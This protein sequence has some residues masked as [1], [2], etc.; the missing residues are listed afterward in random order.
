[1][2][3][4]ITRIIHREPED[5]EKPLSNKEK[6]EK[7]KTM[8]PTRAAL[9]QMMEEYHEES[10]KNEEKYEIYHQRK[11]HAMLLEQTNTSSIIVFPSVDPPWYKIGWNSA[12]IYAY[13]VAMRACKKKDLPT[14]RQDTDHDLRSRDGI[15]FVRN[16]KSFIRRLSEIGLN[17]YEVL[18]DG[19]YV[20]DVNHEYTKGE[21]KELRNIKYRSGEEL[22][23]MTA[24]KKIYPELRGLM[25]KAMSI[26][27]PKMNNLPTL[28]CDTVGAEMAEAIMKMNHVYFEVAN[29][30]VSKHN[31]HVLIVASA[32]TVLED[33]HILQEAEVLS[34][35]AVVEIGK[36]MVDIK[37]AVRRIME[38][39]KRN[40]EKTN[41]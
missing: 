4:T 14:I 1:M 7:L 23:G 30:R 20:F 32:N 27:M 31:S 13:D 38:K 8:K 22:F 19:I 15:I 11:S 9:K 37:A 5:D 39:E 24:E 40:G 36:V 26:I 18:E 41:T 6:M 35:V 10:V 33:L 2:K 12:L 16:L 3:K 25:T 17:K 28:Y 21:L 29:E 34:P